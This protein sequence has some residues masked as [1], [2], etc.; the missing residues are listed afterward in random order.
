MPKQVTRRSKKSDTADT[1]QQLNPVERHDLIALRAYLHAE[2]RGFQ[3]GNPV[4]DWLQAEA[5]ID[6]EVRQTA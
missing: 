1:P 3:G 4:Q 5:E 6:R 2:A